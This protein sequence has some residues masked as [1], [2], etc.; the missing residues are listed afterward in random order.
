MIF[1]TI[2]KSLEDV[3]ITGRKINELNN[4]KLNATNITAY[5][6]ALKRLNAKKAQALALTTLLLIAL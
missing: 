1:K 6:T 5:T 4:L 3:Y 2:R